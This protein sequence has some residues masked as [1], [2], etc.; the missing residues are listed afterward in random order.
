VPRLSV[1]STVH[2]QPCKQ[3]PQVDTRTWAAMVPIIE[4]SNLPSSASFY[5]SVLQPLGLQYIA[6]RPGGPWASSVLGPEFGGPQSKI[7]YGTPSPPSPVLQLQ[8]A[9]AT[10]GQRTISHV[11]LSAPTSAAITDFHASALR[12][13]PYRQVSTGNNHIGG[14]VFEA[15]G[16]FGENRT[17]ITDLDGNSMEVVYVPPASYPSQHGGSTMRRTQSTRG[18]VSR[19]LNWNYEVVASTPSQPLSTA[20]ARHNVCGPR[21]SGGFPDEPYTVLRR[22]VTTST[23]E[24]SPRQT[25]NGLSATTVVGTIL[26]A[27]A[28]AAAG[29]AIT[30]NMVKSDQARAPRQE[31][32]APP[33]QRRVTFPEP[34]DSSLRDGRFVELERTVEKVRYPE[35]YASMAD[36]R[37]PPRYMARYSQAGT[38]KSREFD[39]IYDSRSRHS[40]RS[41][42]S[43]AASARSRSEVP[44]E[45]TP[46]MITDIEHKSHISSRH[47]VAP[48]QTTRPFL[49]S[50][51]ETYVS[52]RSHKSASTIRPLPPQPT[53]IQSEVVNKSRAGSRF[54]TIRV[55]GGT[56]VSIPPNA[57]RSGSYIS[58]RNI[59]LPPSRVGSN[60]T[61]WDDD[62]AS[63]APSDSISCVGSRRSQRN[64]R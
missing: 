44:L 12:A 41:R 6:A 33:F 23:Y 58:A 45:R 40:S 11:T 55:S 28:G 50:D 21:H 34:Y 47:S 53:L 36:E 1:I 24:T 62:A 18:E 17:K 54:T 30:Y 15:P 38:I 19:I 49:D 29:A 42:V 60:H 13:N 59:P 56:P 5:S 8:Q 52:A 37:A 7:T 9:C 14:S 43:R 63:V 16:D 25:P 3:P 2:K 51:H 27:V 31:F 20:V 26:G 61:D 48:K 39:E 22:S 4:V 64:Y 46:L 10:T 57:S 32:G 35:G